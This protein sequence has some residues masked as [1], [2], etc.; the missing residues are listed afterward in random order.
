M[1]VT[2]KGVHMAHRVTILLN[3]SSAHSLRLVE[4]AI[5]SVWVSFI[6]LA[7]AQEMREVFNRRLPAKPAAK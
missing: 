7:N 1:Q 4:L 5:A 2:P 3:S 6:L